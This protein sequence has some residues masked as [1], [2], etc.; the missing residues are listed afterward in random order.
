MVPS[1]SSRNSRFSF[2]SG[3]ALAPLLIHFVYSIAQSGGQGKKKSIFPI[4]WRKK[5]EKHNMFDLSEY[6]ERLSEKIDTFTLKTM[7]LSANL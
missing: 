5:Q 1:I 3:N 7:S 4:L 2:S 6:V